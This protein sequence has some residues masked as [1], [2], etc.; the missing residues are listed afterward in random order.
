MVVWEV[1]II[2]NS[3]V[4]KMLKFEGSAIIISGLEPWSFLRATGLGDYCAAFLFWRGA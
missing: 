3:E 2:N 1:T 4:V